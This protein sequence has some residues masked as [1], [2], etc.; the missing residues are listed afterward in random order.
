MKVLH[1]TVN[2][3]LKSGKNKLMAGCKKLLRKIDDF[4]WRRFD[5]RMWYDDKILFFK[6][7]TYYHREVIILFY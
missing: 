1:K 7:L 5:G 2:P 6:D 4:I 3:C